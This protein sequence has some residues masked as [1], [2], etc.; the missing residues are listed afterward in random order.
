MRC[1]PP[2]PRPPARPC[3]AAAWTDWSSAVDRCS[4]PVPAGLARYRLV[5]LAGVDG[6][7][8]TF[9]LR[10]AAA[11]PGR[12]RHPAPPRL[13]P[14][15]QLPVEAVAGA[16]PAQRPQPQGRARRRPHRLSRVRRSALAGLAVPV[17]AGDRQR[18]RHLVALSSL[19]RPAR[20]AGRS[21]R[22]RHAGRPRGRHRARR[23][24]ASGRSATGSWPC[25]RRRG[26]WSCSTGRWLRSVPTGP[27]CSSTAISPGDVRST[28]A[29]PRSSACRWWRMTARPRSVLDRLGAAGDGALP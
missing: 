19:G 13:D 16:D 9:L 2:R 26:W 5:A 18:A 15:S 12:G 28:S 27:T 23:R 21:L 29:W 14:V 25:C 8:K 10:R 3:D 17:P 20:G 11:P 24:R 4:T 1:S 22:L 7:G 6:G